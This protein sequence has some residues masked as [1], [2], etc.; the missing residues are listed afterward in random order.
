MKAGIEA[1]LFSFGSEDNLLVYTI[2]SFVATEFTPCKQ[3]LFLRYICFVIRIKAK[4]NK[5]GSARRVQNS[6]NIAPIHNF[7][8]RKLKLFYLIH[9]Y[10]YENKVLYYNVRSSINNF[11]ST[12]GNPLHLRKRKRACKIAFNSR[13]GRTPPFFNSW[14]TRQK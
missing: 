12:T 4:R 5:R 1:K 14:L 11:I 9:K 3:N 2:M 8:Y 13:A 7:E 6:V 10:V